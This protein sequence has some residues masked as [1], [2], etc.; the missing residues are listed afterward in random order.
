MSKKTLLLCLCIVATLVIG[1]GSTLAYLTDTDTKVNTFTVGNVDIMVDE[2]FE[3]NSPL[4]PGA[5]VNKDAQIVNTGAAPA[6]VWM[7]VA[8]PSNVAPYLQ[9]NWADGVQPDNEAHNVI[10]DDGNEYTVYTVY[11]DEAPLD[12]GEET[13]KLLDSV[14]L[15]G[16]VDYQNGEFVV[17][18]NG[19]VTPIGEDL[20]ELDV[21]VSGYAVQTEGFDTFGEAYNA[22]HAQW[23]DP[24]IPTDTVIPDVV[25]SDSDALA[26]AIEN[27]EADTPVVIGLENGEYETNFKLPGGSDVT[28]V[29]DE[30]TVLSGQ[31]ATTS[32]TNGTLTLKNLTYEVSDA[33]ED[34]TGISQTGKSAIAV[35]GNQNVVCE[36]VTFEMSKKDSTAITT[37]WDTNEGTSVV[38]RDCTFNCNGQRPVRATGNVTIENC[39]FNDPYRYALQLT[40]KSSTAGLQDKAVV[41]FNGNTIVNGPNGKS[42]VYGIQ[43]EGADYGC[44]DLIINGS[45]NTIVDGGADSAMYYCECG[46]VD[47]ASV[48]CNTESALV[49]ENP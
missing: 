1:L 8:V 42:F 27:I 41:N 16:A 19:V 39:T 11:V 14:T 34:S 35:W 4:A 15:S 26:E 5:T 25:V 31:I 47:H 32:S 28:I 13:G 24:T 36:N 20:S 18:E 21:I 7:T 40:A 17:V 22:Y 43:L 23:N 44:S 38:L 45:N 46:K 2:D 29:G 9:L 3:Q 48:V 10:G 49:H 12:A 30:N 6:W 37:W 33:I